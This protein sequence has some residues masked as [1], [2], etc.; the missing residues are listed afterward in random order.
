M[1]LDKAV[2]N[3]FLSATIFHS[4]LVAMDTL[5]RN[6]SLNLLSG[7]VCFTQYRERAGE[8]SR[9]LVLGEIYWGRISLCESILLVSLSSGFLLPSDRLQT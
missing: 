4:V 9:L 7:S 8:V 6:E 5:R 3:C 1:F 2:M